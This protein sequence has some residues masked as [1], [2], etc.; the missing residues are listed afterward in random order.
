MGHSRQDLA[1]R[2]SRRNVQVFL[3]DVTIAILFVFLTGAVGQALTHLATV[4]LK[5]IVVFEWFCEMESP[6]E[7]SD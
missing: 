4:V 1:I 7:T 5:I 3:E 2:A 6:C